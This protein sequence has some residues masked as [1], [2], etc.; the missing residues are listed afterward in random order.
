MRQFILGLPREPDNAGRLDGLSD[1]GI[2]WSIV[3]PLIKPGLVILAVI[4][5]R[6][7][8]ELPLAPHRHDERRSA[9]PRG[10]RCQASRADGN[11]GRAA[12]HSP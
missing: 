4:R 12:D 2:Y 9:G 8:H 7:V 10:R 5:H 11:E 6:S 3:L 1:F